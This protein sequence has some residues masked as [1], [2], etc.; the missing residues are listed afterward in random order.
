MLME[1]LFYLWEV[2]D[3]MCFFVDNKDVWLSGFFDCGLFVEILDGWVKIVV[4]GRV[5]Y[6]F[7]LL[8]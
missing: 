4:C 5:R 3:R 2:V 8:F 1:N 7:V 6:N